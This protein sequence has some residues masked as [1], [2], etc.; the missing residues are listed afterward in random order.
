MIYELN[1]LKRK[2]VYPKD[3]IKT[4]LL[5]SSSLDA[6]SVDFCQ[7]AEQQTKA[8]H[9]VCGLRNEFTGKPS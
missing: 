3:V 4:H 5:I 2:S 9:G 6:A 7:K 8:P 1:E